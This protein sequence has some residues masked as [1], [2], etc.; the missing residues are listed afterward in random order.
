MV[1]NKF[2][3][4][5]KRLS[6]PVF[7]L[8]A[9]AMAQAAEP[10]CPEAHRLDGLWG[11][12]EIVG[13]ERYGGSLLSKEKVAE[14]ARGKLEFQA[15]YFR[16]RG[17]ELKAPHYKLKCQPAVAEGSVP[18]PS[19]RFSNFYGFGMERKTI[20]FIDVYSEKAA[21]HPLHRLEVVGDELWELYAGW[22]FKMKRVQE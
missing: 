19:D 13:Y 11:R 17:T 2:W 4:A 5:V 22:L 7:L 18:S 3:A 8:L 14:L 20:K 15:D 10:S 16:L 1:M 12:Y 9:L 21:R 6:A